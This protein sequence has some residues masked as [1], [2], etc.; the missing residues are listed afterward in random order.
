MADYG[1]TRQERF[2]KNFG[3]Q[4]VSWEKLLA[5]LVGSSTLVLLAYVA[6]QWHRPWM[7]DPVQ[8]Q[9]LR[10]CRKLARIGLVRA[11]HEGA[12]DFA[13]RCL[14]KRVDLQPAIEDITA[15]YLRLRYDRAANEEEWRAFKREVAAF[16]P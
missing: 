10:F 11:P 6:W 8:R 7:R 5:L 1:K 13:H 12:L 14:T 2:L 15:K 16:R 9:Y 3:I 4:N